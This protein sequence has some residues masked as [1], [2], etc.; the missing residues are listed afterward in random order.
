[1][2]DIAERA[3]RGLPLDD[4][5]IIDCHC[6]MGCWQHFNVPHGSAEGM[7]TSMDALGV[8]RAFVTA[9]SSIGP[10]YRYGNDMVIEAVKKYP[11]RFIGYTTVNPNYPGDMENELKRCFEWSGMRGIKL[12]PACHGHAIDYRNYRIAYETAEQRKCPVLI[13]VW[14]I[15]AVM[16]VDRLADQYPNAVFIMGHGGADI[17]AMEAAAGVVGRHEN[18]YVDIAISRVREGNV[19]WLVKEMG[20]K[21]I[22][23][24]TD[25]PFFDPRPAFGR[26]AFADI[27]EDE[28]KDIFG[29]NMDRLLNREVLK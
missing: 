27:G 21:K 16:T 26:V 3:R 10:D 7:L 18:V 11:G 13:H 20:S 22:L 23:Y 15:G 2:S 4:I 29:L 12:H 6:H 25:M 28:K 14:G 19:E 9:H 24:G 1:M 17:D 5:L 8:D